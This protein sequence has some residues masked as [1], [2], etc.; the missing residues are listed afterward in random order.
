M[1]EE[2]I[3]G[4]GIQVSPEKLLPLEITGTLF[5]V[6]LL[7]FAAV[8]LVMW[9]A[10]D[11]IA[12]G[13]LSHAEVLLIVHMIALGWGTAVALGAWQQLSVVA[14]Q[15]PGA[16]RLTPAWLSLALF[17]TG[18]PLFLLGL[19][20]SKHTQASVGGTFMIGAFLAAIRTSANARAVAQRGTV[21]S[22]FVIGAL[23]SLVLV[24]V[25]GVILAVNRATGWLGTGYLAAFKS[26][27][28]L[29]PVG[30]FGLLIPGVSYELAPFFGITRVGK[31]AGRGKYPKIV[32]SLI[33]IGLIGGIISSIAGWS[34]SLMLLPLAV[35]YIV[36]VI[37]LRGIFRRR[38]EIRRTATLTGVRASHVWLLVAS[39]IILAAAVAGDRFWEHRWS[40]TVG[41]IVAA[42]WVS[43]AVAG[44]LHRILPFLIWHHRYWGK[45]KEEIK[46]SFPKMVDQKLGRI[47]F[48]VYHAG[49]AAVAAGLWWTA[50]LPYAI[51][52]FS[53]GVWILVC[54]LAWTYFK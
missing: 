34:I 7:V 44:Y 51:A 10:R 31:D 29:G 16:P 52:L 4:T 5:G 50:V 48:A 26:H 11:L 40:M 47:G 9:F 49:V 36:F 41:W 8:P 39:V 23:S 17:I 20:L 35:G 15:A 38:G 42:G 27:V 28:Y 43:S 3:P 37:D 22:L 24:G 6:G 14:L 46:T 19:Y 18:L 32:F 45:K 30:W 54:N 33:A 21:M 25:V 53:I 12:A 13:S 1:P 2:A